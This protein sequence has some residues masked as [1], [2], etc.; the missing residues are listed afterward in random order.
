MWVLGI[1]AAAD[2]DIQMGTSV[3]F[4]GRKGVNLSFKGLFSYD[5]ISGSCTFGLLLLE[6]DISEIK[7]QTQTTWFL[8]VTLRPAQLTSAVMLEVGDYIQ[9]EATPALQVGVIAVGPQRAEGPG[10]PVEGRVVEVVD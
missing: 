7:V 9:Q 2:F 10:A 5:V 1:I 3:L 8:S 6:K 4:L